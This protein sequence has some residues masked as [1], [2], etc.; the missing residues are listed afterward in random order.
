MKAV[1]LTGHG[2]PEKLEYR[3]DVPATEPAGGEVLVEVGATGVN[4]TD[5][6]TR[7]GLYGSE[8]DPQS[9][10]GWRR[11]RPMRFPRIQG[12]DI[13]GR[14]A[15]VG[16]GVPQARIGERVLVDPVV[17]AGEGRER[18][19]E[20]DMI[21]SERDGG[22]AGY[23]AVPA[24]NAY[25]V[26]TSLTD[27]EL[28]TFPTAYL[29]AEGMLNRARVGQDETLLVTGASGGV[30]SALLQLARVRG[31]RTVA[32]VGSGKEERARELGAEAVITR[33]DEDLSESVSEAME[34]LGVDVV[35][36]VVGGEAFSEILRSLRPFGRYVTAG[37]IAGPLV[38]LDLR[39]LYLKQL[40]LIGS[41][42]GTHEEFADL[43]GYVER[44]GIKPLLAGVYPL[45]R[46]NEA[47]KEFEEKS[48][49]GKLVVS[50]G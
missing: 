4:N 37:A 38:G 43:V 10:G 30:G 35:A 44:G 26:D 40:E 25:V 22:F 33:G 39:T 45:S 3:E 21:G 49:F 24:P 7:R 14:I 48:F 41:T 20:A 11:D 15:E 6:W 18:L 32:L 42:A 28:A 27:E 16:E 36:D 50:P 5:L 12:M 19:A 29:T 46:I 17:Y 1:L 8:S 31:A 34:G 13:A 23:V 47:Q 9:T 2:G